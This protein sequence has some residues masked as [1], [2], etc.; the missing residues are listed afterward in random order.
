[1]LDEICKCTLNRYNVVS[2]GVDFAA[3]RRIGIVIKINSCALR[4]RRLCWRSMLMSILHYCRLSHG[5]G[6]PV[7]IRSTYCIY[8]IM[9]IISSASFRSKAYRSHM[10]WLRMRSV[11]K[12]IVNLHWSLFAYN[13]EAQFSCSDFALLSCECI[14]GK[15]AT[16]A[17]FAGEERSHHQQRTRSSHQITCR[18]TCWDNYVA[19]LLRPTIPRSNFVAYFS[20]KL[21]FTVKK[22]KPVNVRRVDAT[23]DRVFFRSFRPFALFC[24]GLCAIFLHSTDFDHYFVFTFSPSSFRPPFDSVLFRSFLF[25][26]YIQFRMLFSFA[27]PRSPHFDG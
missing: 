7:S 22:N 14:A 12:A 11:S 4:S 25:L 26:F 24:V 19:A 20:Y 10:K 15:S 18:S 13:I 17:L 3:L 9:F 5:R 2:L 21:W 8:F 6:R 1:M 23:P 16:S 27:S